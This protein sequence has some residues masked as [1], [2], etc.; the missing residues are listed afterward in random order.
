M[1]ANWVKKLAREYIEKTFTIERCLVVVDM[2]F[3]VLRSIAGF[4]PGSTDDEAVARWEL[5]KNDIAAAIQSK[6]MELLLPG[7]QTH[8]FAADPNQSATFKELHDALQ[9]VVKE[10]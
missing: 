8:Q 1:F 4:V 7:L 3:S 6:L 2:F 10:N 9:E 5:K